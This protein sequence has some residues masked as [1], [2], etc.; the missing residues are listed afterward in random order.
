VKE[1]DDAVHELQLFALRRGMIPIAGII[2]RPLDS[3]L[4]DSGLLEK[5]HHEILGFGHN[6]LADGVPGVHGETGAVKGMG[7]VAGGY[8]DL[9]ATSSLSPCPFCQCTLAR[10]LGIKTIRILDDRNYRPDKGDYQRVGVTPLVAPHASIESTFA[11]WVN[12]PVNRTLWNRDIGIPVGARGVPRR[13]APEES[14][15]LVRRAVRLALEGAQRGEIPIGAVIVDELGQVVGSSHA[16]I[17]TDN[18]PSKTAAMAAWRASGS[19]NDWGKYTLVL[20]AGPDPVALSMFKIFGFGQLIVAS[21]DVYRGHIS[22]V[23]AVTEAVVIAGG[24]AD[25]D[26]ALSDWLKA[27]PVALAR[28]YLGIAWPS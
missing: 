18:D 19:R 20:S 4:L 28:E 11:E 10:Q 21:A 9:V 27:H 2:S 15:A 14:Q 7:R 8:Q 24:A 17:V 23:Q 25:S 12:D 1:L 26:E 16:K 13:F 3:R 6:E 5:G 22:E